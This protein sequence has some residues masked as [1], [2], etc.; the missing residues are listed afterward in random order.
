V[1]NQLW[2]IGERATDDVSERALRHMKGP[3]E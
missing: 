2:T 1:M 3:A